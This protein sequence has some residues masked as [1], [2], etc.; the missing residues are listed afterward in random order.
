M[1]KQGIPQL[2]PSSDLLSELFEEPVSFYALA[3]DNE[4]STDAGWNTDYIG[5]DANS[6]SYPFAFFSDTNLTDGSW[7][8]ENENGG[9]AYSPDFLSSLSETPNS[10]ASSFCS[11]FYDYGT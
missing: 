8:L 3:V 4:P 10:Y 9:T 2:D 7:L 1:R 5:Y 11:S 6:I